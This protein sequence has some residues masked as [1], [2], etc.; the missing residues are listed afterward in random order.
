[1]F[2]S[3]WLWHYP[4]KVAS[5]FLVFSGCVTIAF[6][7]QRVLVYGQEPSYII[8]GGLM[9]LGAGCAMLVYHIKKGGKE[10]T[11]VK[12]KIVLIGF[13]AAM[14]MIALEILILLSNVLYY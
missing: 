4:A 3:T 12:K 7:L 5:G 1:M 14:P 8:A 13:A 6:S 10:D 2:T 9:M 11:A